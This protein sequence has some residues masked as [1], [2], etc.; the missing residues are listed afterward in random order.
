MSAP[1]K[2]L[3]PN[4]L[5]ITTTRVAS[6]L[7]AV[8][9]ACAVPGGVEVPWTD[10]V[11]E[12]LAALGVTSVSPIIRDFSFPGPWKAMPHQHNVASFMV[13]NPRSFVFA[14]MGTG[15]TAAA[16]WACAYLRS[17][18]RIKRVLVVCPVSIMVDAWGS[19]LFKCDIT[20]T[21]AL[22]HGSK[23]QRLKALA[24]GRFWNIINFDGVETIR[25]ELIAAEFDA[26]IIDESRAYAN[27]STN[28][29]KQL[30]AV[31]EK[32]KYVWALSGTPTTKSPMDAHGQAAIIKPGSVSNKTRF[33][34]ATMNQI[35]PHV[36]IP[37]AGAW[38][39][40]TQVLSPAI[41]IAKKDVLKDMPP[42]THTY[43]KVELSA[44]QK[45]AMSELRS[46]GM[47]DIGAGVV[48]A[49]TA[50][51]RRIKLL[52]IASGAVYDDT[53]TALQ[54]DVDASPRIAELLEVIEGT[55]R[56]VLVLVSFRHTAAM[57][58]DKL[59]PL[60]FKTITGDTPRAQRTE[61]LAALQSGAIKG[62]VAVAQTMSH[63]ITATA[64]DTTV[65]FSPPIAGAETYIQ[66]NNRMDRPGQ[67]FSM[68]IVHLYG[69][70]L[71][72]D[73]Y[74]AVQNAQGEQATFLAAYDRF[75]K[76]D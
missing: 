3:T 7:D 59:A 60:G 62:V 21:Y 61:T 63:G 37:K 67:L 20:K 24:L 18:G 40:V 54:Y 45:R 52:Q 70:P 4:I 28:R 55:D 58:G 47:A 12:R 8:P 9:S 23:A 2:L 17:I 22:L 42:V 10:T 65:W 56:G 57:L 16:I 75:L 44:G 41:R 19:D 30:S 76:G 68:Q 51:A 33:R 43:R 50:A 64:A 38:D 71:E 35:R 36:W 48:S 34:D 72:R 66:A 27:T 49:V 69:S 31:S 46:E 39:Y 25:P 26:I 53:G 13:L 32:T 14:D 6:I 29:W 74:T 5:Q 15:K 1:I 11:A 73:V